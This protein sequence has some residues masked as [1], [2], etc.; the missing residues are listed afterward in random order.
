MLFLYEFAQ[1]IIYILLNFI[2]KYIDNYKL[3]RFCEIRE[4]HYFVREL[5]IAQENFLKIK[6]KE[7]KD[8]SIYWFHV[9]SAGEL[10]QAIPIARKLHEKSNTY[11]LLTYFSPSTEP[12]IKNFPALI[13]SFGLPI[14]ARK[15]YNMIFNT[16]PISK[17]FFVRYDIW[18]A[19]FY[20]VSKLNIEMNLLSASANKTKKGVFGYLSKIWNIKFYRKFANIFAVNKDD[21]LFFN[22]FLPQTKVYYAGD[23][24]WARALE[25]ANNCFKRK[26]EKDFSYFF[27][28]CLAQREVLNK[29]NIIFGSPHKE[30]HK[31]ALDCSKIKE[32]V[33]IIY[34]PHDVKENSCKKIIDEFS[35]VGLFAILYSEF[36]IKVHE[37]FSTDL[38]DNESINIEEIKQ[39]HTLNNLKR[40][41]K[42]SSQLL[43]SYDAIV[44]DKIGYL[45]EIYE[46]SDVSIIG[47]G[48]DGQIH[49]VLEA[50][51][52]GV[53][54][55]IGSLFL[56]ASEAKELVRMGGAISFQNSNELFQFLVQWVSLEEQGTDSPHPAR[57]LAQSKS[58][59]LELFRSI[60]D[61]SEI[62]LQALK[63]EQK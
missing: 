44:F 13:S 48:F 41:V 9:A 51:A 31:I 40:N 10:E 16:L 33:F 59:S 2:S 5:K 38:L 62:V 49:N 61:T 11:F 55:L 12:F 23:A 34:V 42:I 27:S 50:A 20:E 56:R 46:L 17:V 1:K 58:R 24:K 52:H 60:P 32:K 18:P 54:V 29:K 14:D 21:V 35:S 28:F 47:G 63:K 25:R 4:T 43:S 22:Q 15:N 8:F 19:L 37:H 6:T 7:N 39:T 26:N 57:L 45:A 53:P 36:I 3:K 30:E